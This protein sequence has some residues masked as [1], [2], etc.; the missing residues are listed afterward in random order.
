MLQLNPNSRSTCSELLNHPFFNEEPLMTNEEFETFQ[1]GE[2]HEFNMNKRRAENLN[3]NGI[4]H[5]KVAG[6]PYKDKG[7]DMLNKK[8]FQN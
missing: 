2:S 6:V 1:I 4:Q 3:G 5:Q 7:E 8:R